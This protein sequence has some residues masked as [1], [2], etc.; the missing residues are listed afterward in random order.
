MLILLCRLFLRLFFNH[1]VNVKCRYLC[2]TAR[3]FSASYF[4][5]LVNSCRKSSYLPATQPRYAKFTPILTFKP[6]FN[7]Y[8]YYLY[9]I[10]RSHYRDHISGEICFKCMLMVDTS[11]HLHTLL[12][13][14]LLLAVNRQDK[15][16]S[17]YESI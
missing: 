3:T 1:T 5:S 8:I 6:C 16:Q 14:T 4:L 11:N 2:I 12:A 10:V 13:R 7:I 9:A 15:Q 17:N